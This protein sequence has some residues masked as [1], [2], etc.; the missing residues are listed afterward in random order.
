MNGE[1]DEQAG[2]AAR[3]QDRFL[4]IANISRCGSPCICTCCCL[5]GCTHSHPRITQNP[6][7]RHIINRSLHVSLAWASKPSIRGAAAAT[8]VVLMLLF[9]FVWCC[10]R[11]VG[12]VFAAPAGL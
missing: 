3:E 8:V 10:C 2:A 6:K 1:V 11:C 5:T 12:V 9:L 7:Y 4:P